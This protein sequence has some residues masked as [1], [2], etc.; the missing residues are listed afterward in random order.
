MCNKSVVQEVEEFSVEG[1]TGFKRENGNLQFQVKWLGYHPY[2][3]TWEKLSNLKNSK[4]L[5]IEY[6]KD[7]DLPHLANYVV[8]Y[9][10]LRSKHSKQ[11]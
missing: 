9:F 1:I 2:E 6:L 7:N 11:K 4:D 10:S 8:K 3:S 5:V